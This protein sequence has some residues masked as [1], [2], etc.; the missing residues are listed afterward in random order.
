MNTIQSLI[1]FLGRA[2]LSIIF[3]YSGVHQILDWQGTQHSFTQGLNDWL[4]MSIGNST[5]Q[6]IIEF[7]MS[8]AF[9]LLLLG[10]I[11]ETV[12][13][14]LLF[15]GLWVRFGA[16]LLIIFFLI[17]TA[18]AFHHYWEIRGPDSEIHLINFMK[19]VSILGG[20]L[21]LLAMGKGS[22]Q[23]KGHVEAD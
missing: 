21:F 20:L 11:V 18:L 1:A 8:H 23:V 15:L 10:V 4:A 13:G 14:L 17:P 7:G 2:L 22:K 3:I 19:N 9:I 5:L 12:G 6:D 16:L